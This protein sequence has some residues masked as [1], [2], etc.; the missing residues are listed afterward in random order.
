MDFVSDSPTA[1]SGSLFIVVVAFFFGE[2]VLL[3]IVAAVIPS[4][5][6]YR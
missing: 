1:L 5:V 6:R 2:S 3:V 4:D